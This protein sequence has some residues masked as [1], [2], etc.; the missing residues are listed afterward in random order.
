MD[1]T[2]LRTLFIKK[3]A[4]LAESSYLLASSQI[5]N[6]F[7]VSTDLSS[8]H[9]VHTFLPMIE[10]KEVDTWLIIDRIKREFPH[11][12]FAIPKINRQ[13]NEL[14]HFF[15]DGPSQ[16]EE[17]RWGIP[18]PKR[19]TAIAPKDI[20]LV[21]VPLLAF[22]AKGNRVGYGKGYYDKF[23]AQCRPDCK[24]I[25]LSLFEQVDFIEANDFDVK[26]DYCI[27]PKKFHAF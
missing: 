22:D 26:L 21:L 19:G 20:D 11:L 9:V 16:L 6:H 18:E 12:K 10:R 5:A 25:G 23:L 3:R 13:L 17:N 14:E 24:K 7:F 4:A 27:T 1:K 8:I 15:F 2:E